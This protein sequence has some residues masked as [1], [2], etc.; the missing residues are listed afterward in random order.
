MSHSFPLFVYANYNWSPVAPFLWIWY[1]R[2]YHSTCGIQSC[3][4][5]W[6]NQ[7]AL[8]VKR[9]SPMF[10][11]YVSIKIRTILADM[12][13]TFV[14][15]NIRIPPHCLVIRPGIIPKSSI[16]N[17]RFSAPLLDRVR[18][19][20][21]FFLSFFSFW[22]MFCIFSQSSR[23]NSVSD[24]T[25]KMS[26]CSVSLSRC[27]RLVPSPPIPLAVPRFARGGADRL[28]TLAVTEPMVVYSDPPDP[29]HPNLPHRAY[30]GGLMHNT[31]TSEFGGAYSRWAARFSDWLTRPPHPNASQIAKQYNGK[32][33]LE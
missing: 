5:S 23:L 10:A 12:C 17:L 16:V 29:L 3:C 2:L 8:F 4:I 11:P 24:L 33:W 26:D 14:E 1:K 9:I 30:L 28:T 13:A 19:W 27:D 18:M 25:A 20:V 15:L 32:K 21:C 22:L 31:D 7:R 6:R